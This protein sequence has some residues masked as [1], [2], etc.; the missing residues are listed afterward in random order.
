[1][2]NQNKNQNTDQSKKHFNYKKVML[3]IYWDK[4]L[5]YHFFRYRLP[6][7]KKDNGKYIERRYRKDE[8]LKFVFDEGFNYKHP[9]D[10][11]GNDVKLSALWRSENKKYLLRINELKA[12]RSTDINRGEYHLPSIVNS[13]CFFTYLEEHRNNPTKQ[14]KYSTKMA[15]NSL[16]MHLKA[17]VGSNKLP[18]EMLDNRFVRGFQNYLTSDA[19]NVL[20]STN[21]G[22]LGGI[23]ILKRIKDFK[24]IVGKAVIDEIIPYHPF[25]QFEIYEKGRTPKSKFGDWLEPEELKLLNDNPLPY[26][27]NETYKY[28]MFACNAC[29][30]WTECYNLTW[31]QITDLKK[32]SKIQY[33]RQKTGAFRTLHISK[34]ARAYLGER[35][36]PEDKVFDLTSSV[37]DINKRLQMWAKMNGIN[38][39]LSTH[40][41]KRTF[42]YC[43]YLKTKDIFAL[44]QILGHNDLKSTQRYVSAFQIDTSKKMEEITLSG[45]L[46]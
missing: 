19:P 28:F 33:K 16:E 7:I 20:K 1:M 24:Y 17:Y 6:S 11:D 42:A 14:Y 27:Y 26:E 10:K 45:G 22:K 37:D 31:G 2:T 4:R 36:N 32:I 44:Q 21:G 13:D 12:E 8:S 39:H 9:V 25:G 40:A 23:T 5:G 43:F 38:K 35:G 34:Q 3:S 18:F 41:A 29:M 15:Y 46:F 30:A